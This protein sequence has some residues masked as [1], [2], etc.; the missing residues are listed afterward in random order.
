VSAEYRQLPFAV[1]PD[2]TEIVLAR[3]GAS[4]PARPGELFPLLDGH[5]DP[6]LAP[7]GREQ[8][9]LLCARLR[10]EQVDKVFV[11][12]LARTIETA[13]PLGLPTTEV[14]ELR[15]VMLGEWEGGPFR[16]HVANGEPLALRVIAQERWDLIP[17]AETMEQLAERVRAGIDKVVE[18][19]GRGKVAL[20]FIH[21]GIIGEICRQATSSRPFAFVHSDNCSITRIVRFADG[22]WLLRSFNDTSHL[23]RGD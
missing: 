21:G 20:V 17:G 7:E 1:P 3:H 15:E 11:T 14:P 16:I 5:G 2:A 10:H 18:Q 6:A 22:R 8:A 12:G 23:D 9:E 4:A 13:A 19:T